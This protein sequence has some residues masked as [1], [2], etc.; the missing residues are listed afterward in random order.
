MTTMIS[1]LSP[2]CKRLCTSFGLATIL[3]LSLV[4]IA[5]AQN[6]N[7]NN[8]PKLVVFLVADQFAS[9]YLSI[10][11]GKTQANG[12]KRLLDNGANF[13][14]CHYSST[15]NQTA[16]NL[17]VIASS[18]YPW[19]SGIISN[20]WYDRHKQKIVKAIASE[21]STSDENIKSGN[22]HAL[23]GTTIGDELK[24]ATN[25]ASRVVSIAGGDQDAIL[26]AGKLGDQAF[27]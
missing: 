18:A 8:R 1:L 20:Q 21:S 14:A 3:C 10:C 4:T 15:T 13:T 24:I 25:G 16:P 6:N 2:T 22:A 23:A 12:F 5:W 7:I 27:W 17:A 26:W 11:L 19:S 9:N